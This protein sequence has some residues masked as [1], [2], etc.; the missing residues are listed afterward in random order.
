[1]FGLAT[2]YKPW[3]DCANTHVILIQ[4]MEWHAC[5]ASSYILSDRAQE[6]R[7][8]ALQHWVTFLANEGLCN[9]KCGR[10]FWGR[11]GP[12]FAMPLLSGPRV[13]MQVRTQLGRD[14]TLLVSSRRAK[15]TLPNLLNVNSSQLYRDTTTQL[16]LFRFGQCRTR[17][18]P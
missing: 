8:L 12:W 5:H 14:T 13:L 16:F 17:A 4:E 11:F 18:S 15:R 6:L 3:K 7:L 1:M 10:A 9:G 2:T